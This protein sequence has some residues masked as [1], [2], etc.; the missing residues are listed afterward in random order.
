MRS[1][2]GGSL[3]KCGDAAEW[4][5][6]N[7]NPLYKFMYPVNEY[8]NIAWCGKFCQRNGIGTFSSVATSGLLTLIFLRYESCNRG[9]TGLCQPLHS[10]FLV[11]E[12]QSRHAVA[13]FTG[14]ITL[15]PRDEQLK[16]VAEKREA[17]RV[18]FKDSPRHTMMVSV[19]VLDELGEDLGVTPTLGRLL[20][21]GSCCGT[22][23]RGRLARRRRGRASLS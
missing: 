12:I 9:M 10:Q 16:D 21:T 23:R 8:N 5:Q 17:M 19:S 13:T 15:P 11:S 3:E 4:K 18:Q 6:D 7:E 14:S 1:C 22:C 20:R 2:T